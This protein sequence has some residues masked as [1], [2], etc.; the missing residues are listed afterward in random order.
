M[1]IKYYIA[2]ID[3][4]TYE[5]LL[6]KRP[7]KTPGGS[8]LAIPYSKK[9]LALLIAGEWEAQNNLLKQH[10]LPLVSIL[11][12]THTYIKNIYTLYTYF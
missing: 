9:H 1:N 4:Q 10:S 7:L 3:T 2:I 12:R 8:K 6:D 5:I 11:R